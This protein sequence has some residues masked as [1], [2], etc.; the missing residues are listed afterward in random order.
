MEP[1]GMQ[2]DPWVIAWAAPG[3]IKANLEQVKKGDPDLLLLAEPSPHLAGGGEVC[4]QS[5]L[6]RDSFGF[7]SAQRCLCERASG[8]GGS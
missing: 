4:V 3:Q 8:C 7:C 5:R 1:P 2:P 6:C